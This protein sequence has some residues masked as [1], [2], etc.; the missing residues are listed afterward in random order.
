MQSLTSQLRRSLEKNWEHLEATFLLCILIKVP[1]ADLKPR[2]PPSFGQIKGCVAD[3]EG[4]FDPVC[5]LRGKTTNFPL[6]SDGMA[7]CQ[8]Q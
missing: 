8:C 1:S 2:R 6:P 5:I 4:S 7:L 3:E